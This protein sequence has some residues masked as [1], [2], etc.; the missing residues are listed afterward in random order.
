MALVVFSLEQKQREQLDLFRALPGDM[1]PRDAQDLMAYPFF[2]LAKSRRTAPID[3]RSG[4]VTVR[5]EGTQEHGIATIWDA[6]ILIW[7]ASQIV[8]ARDAGIRP[9]RWMHATPYEILRFIG[10]GTSLRDYQRLKAALDRLQSTTVATSIRE[11]T[12]RRLHRF[13]WINEWK[14]RAD[15]NGVPLGLELI[16]P[17]WFYAGVLDEA[18]VLT[19]DPAYFKL[20]GGIERWLYRLVRKHGGKQ[21]CGWQFDFPY[22]YR[23]SGSLAQPRDFARDLRLLAARQSLPG[24]LLSV[25]RWPGAPE[26]LAFRPVPSTAR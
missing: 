1:A 3:F 8:E 5:V 15:A 12:G 14:E 18:L 4:G 6:D 23:K 17:D 11:T 2:S 7:A 24:Y 22:L 10:R 9:S 13:S 20:T 25:E 16:L 26:I 19:I 21:E